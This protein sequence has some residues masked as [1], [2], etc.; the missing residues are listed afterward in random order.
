MA[1]AHNPTVFVID[2]DASISASVQGLL[3][4]E[5]FWS[6]VLS[7]C[8]A[9]EGWSAAESHSVVGCHHRA[10]PGLAERIYVVFACRS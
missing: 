7:R 8:T 5:G 6:D 9:G 4:S 3:K 10:L 2:D 1:L